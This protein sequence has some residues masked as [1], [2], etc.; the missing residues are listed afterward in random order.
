MSRRL[1][2]VF[3]AV[4]SFAAVIPCSAP[5]SAGGFGEVRTVRSVDLDRYTGRWFNL[6]SIPSPFLERCERDIT[7][8]YEVLD[9]G[10]VRV[11][12]TCTTGGRSIPIEGR[13][14]V[15]EPETNAELQV[16]FA[17]QNGEFIFVPGG[18]YW[19]IG[20]DRDYEWAVVGDPDRSGGFVLSRTSTLGA[21]EIVGV[22]FSLLRSGYDPCRFELTPT[23]G[24]LEADGSICAPRVLRQLAG[25]GSLNGAEVR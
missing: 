11:V 5:A 3:A 2:A 12:N 20:L 4:A 14:R 17:R 9:D 6:A 10:L 24:G 15:V 19:V 7:A 22:L 21:R 23:T 25:V 8:D 16:T 18:D 1:V 13:A